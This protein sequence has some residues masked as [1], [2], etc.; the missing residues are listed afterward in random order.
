[1][2]DLTNK[3]YGSAEKIEIS[4]KKYLKTSNH[5]SLMEA[6][7]NKPGSFINVMANAFSMKYL[8]GRTVSYWK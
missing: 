2:M 7:G 5:N 8:P 1:M 3:E 4:G 6:L